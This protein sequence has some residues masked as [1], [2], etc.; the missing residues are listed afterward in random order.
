MTPA[1]HARQIDQQEFEAESKAIVAR[2]LA[3]AAA[4]QF[5]ERRRVETWIAAGE[6]VMQSMHADYVKRSILKAHQQA[7]VITVDGEARTWQQWAQHLGVTRNTLNHR[8]R[9]LGSREAAIKFEPPVKRVK[10]SEQSATKPRRQ[11]QPYAKQHTSGG[12]SMTQAQWAEHLGLSY[13]AFSQ[14][15][16][17]LGSFDAAVALG[18]KQRPGPKPGVVSNFRAPEGTGGGSTA[19]ESSKITFSEVSENA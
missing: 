1:E 9:K 4:I 2:A 8:F 13:D 11:R 17:R 6:P 19:Q 15:I 12:I 5:S 7:R 18:E 3:R 14:R 10:A 16:Y